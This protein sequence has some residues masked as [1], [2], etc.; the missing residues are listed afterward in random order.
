M[1]RP[2]HP[3]GE[4]NDFV[5]E[6]RALPAGTTAAIW[7]QAR[8]RAIGR[9]GT[10]PWRAPEDMAGFAS[11]TWGSPVIM[12]RRTWASI[13]SRFRPF[14]GRTSLVVTSDA[15]TARSVADA[16]R[17]DARAEAQ[18][19]LEAALA[20]GTELATSG[21]VW[22]AG[23]GSVYDAALAGGLVRAVVV[24]VLDLEVPDADTWAPALGPGFER[25]A[26]SPSPTGFHTN[27]TGP[28]YRFELHRRKAD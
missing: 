3:L 7:A 5:A 21:P 15:A 9:G 11:L 8:D 20:R 22:V 18:G 4:E 1:S 24:T 13:P 16:A 25:V 19:T 14:P 6:V 12:G 27:T 17:D 10:M 23:G 28:S 2:T 26:A